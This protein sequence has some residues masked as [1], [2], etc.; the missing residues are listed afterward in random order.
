MPIKNEISQKIKA[1][2]TKKKLWKFEIYQEDFQLT[3]YDSEYWLSVS[4]K[5][6]RWSGPRQ[7]KNTDI[8]EYIVS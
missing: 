6:C 5:R 3:L 8:L 7:D 1:N 2:F 4:I